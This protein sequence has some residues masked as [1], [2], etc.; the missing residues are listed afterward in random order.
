MGRERSVRASSSSRVVGH[1]RKKPYTVILESV[2]Q[3]RRKLRIADSFEENAPNGYTFVP[4]GNVELTEQCK[5]FCRKKGLK[6][7]NVSTHPSSE[8]RANPGKVSYHLNR[9]GFHF[10]SVVVDQAMEWIG[11][12]LNGRSRAGIANNI[13]RRLKTYGSQPE[14]VAV[15]S[16]MKDLF[17]KMP[18]ESLAVILEHA[19]QQGANRVGTATNLSIERRVQMAVLAHVRHK[20]TNYDRLLKEVGYI[21][22]R[23]TVEK[24]CIEKI[25]EWRGEGQEE[26]D[27]MEDDFREVIVLDDDDDDDSDVDNSGSGHSSPSLEL[28]ANEATADDLGPRDPVHARTNRTEPR[29]TMASRHMEPARVPMLPIGHRPQGMQARPLYERTPAESQMSFRGF[30][31][32]N[33]V[34][35]VPIEPPQATVRLAQHEDAR[36]PYGRPVARADHDF[37]RYDHM[38]RRHHS[39]EAHLVRPGTSPMHRHPEVVQTRP[40]RQQLPSPRDIAVPSIENKPTPYV[41]HQERSFMQASKRLS[42]ADVI[43]LTGTPPREQ[44]RARPEMYD[45]PLHGQVSRYPNP[46]RGGFRDELP[47]AMSHER[48]MLRRR[49][50]EISQQG[51]RYPQPQHTRNDD[52]QTHARLLGQGE[53][54]AQVYSPMREPALRHVV[55]RD[56]ANRYAEPVSRGVE[57]RELQYFHPNQHGPSQRTHA[58]ISVG[59]DRGWDEAQYRS[60][61]DHD[62][63]TP[64][65]RFG[66]TAQPPSFHN[67]F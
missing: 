53:S 40:E 20:H 65:L 50:V 28:V 10:P 9:V 17:P 2:T 59:T 58:L 57:Y 27:E 12:P 22:A 18:P 60:L 43:D 8:A 35:L 49:D 26:D 56:R 32:R 54:T 67:A 24:P 14:K 23:K 34:R 46:G 4:I 47:P 30:D 1:K 31:E 38:P 42:D 41:S 11:I 39:H 19:F 5:E 25:L 55:E 29:A 48:E 6:A 52:Y 44:P 16:A 3:K 63:R 37:Q 51:P 66:R 33:H 36:W 7:Y 13:G 15:R 61:S 64:Q 21:E 62:A 45:G